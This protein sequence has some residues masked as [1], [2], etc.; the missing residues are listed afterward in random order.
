MAEGIYKSD[1]G[2]EVMRRW[3]EVCLG[4][5]AQAPESRVVETSFGQTHALVSGPAGAPVLVV[6]H[7]VMASAPVALRQLEAL[8]DEV[9]LICLDTIGQPGRSAEVQPPWHKGDAYGRWVWEALD[10]LGLERAALFGASLGGYIALQAAQVAPARVERLILWS[11]AGVVGTPPGAGFRL[12]SSMLMHMMLPSEARARRFYDLIY[13][14]FNPSQF[15]Y[16]C[17]AFTHV[18]ASMAAPQQL[19]P[20]RLDALTA[21]VQLITCAHDTMFP[22]EALE[23]RAPQVIPTLLPPVRLPDVKHAPPTDPQRMREVLAP[24]RAFLLD[25]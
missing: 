5:L 7:G 4:Q 11:P 12:S 13:T 15:Q 23:R 25:T 14:D 21:P 3:Y 24:V 10:G 6:L 8:T 22:A 17:D 18:K 19:R 16:F 2:R 20:G 9:R 1:E